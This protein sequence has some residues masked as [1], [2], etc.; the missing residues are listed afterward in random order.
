MEEG[1]TVDYIKKGLSWMLDELSVLEGG[2]WTTTC[3]KEGVVVVLGAP[4]TREDGFV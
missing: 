2:E 3:L 1:V 4:T